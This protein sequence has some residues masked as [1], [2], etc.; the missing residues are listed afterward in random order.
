M[1]DKFV[2]QYIDWLSHSIRSL[3]S[4]EDSL[5]VT[6]FLNPIN[7]HNQIKISYV[8]SSVRISDDSDTCR[9][10]SQEYRI[11]FERSP[12]KKALFDSLINEY[13]MQ[14]ENYE[15]VR[16][17]KEEEFPWTLHYFSI[18]I[19]A[20]QNIFLNESNSQASP[21]YFEP[22]PW[23]L[24]QRIGNTFVVNKIEFRQAV[25]KMG[26]SGLQHKYEFA[27]GKDENRPAILIKAPTEL[28]Q[29]NAQLMLFEWQDYI[30]TVKTSPM[31][32]IIAN[33]IQKKVDHKIIKLI[34]MHDNTVYCPMSEEDIWMEECRKA[35][36]L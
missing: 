34:S 18:G 7:D 8:N 32:Y 29:D 21:N 3:N 35:Q 27:I 28:K 13:S 12:V 11:N 30:K 1:K 24:Y 4:S 36:N 19:M 17:C 15:L 9:E 33:D 22:K 10:I 26:I 2:Q 14:M 20:I 16:Y 5:I 25:K 6:P 23:K 31:L